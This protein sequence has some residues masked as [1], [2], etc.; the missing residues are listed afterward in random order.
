[1]WLRPAVTAPR[2]LAGVTRLSFRDRLFTRGVAQAMTS[3]S[4]ILLGG[5]GAA[6]VLA[7]GLPLVVAPIAAVAAWGAR[8]AVAIPRNARSSGIDPFSLADPWREFV[9]EALQAQSRYQAAVGTALEG[10]LRDR[11][12]E[13]GQRVDDGVEACWRIARRGQHLV[14]ARRNIDAVTA[15][16]EL[17]QVNTHAGENWAKG[18]DL[19]RTAEALRSQLATA[20]RMDEVIAD[21]HSRLRLLDARLDESVARAIELSVSADDAADLVGL[22]A[23]V[24]G[25]VT[26]MEALR[27]AL[28]ETGT[29]S[30]TEAPGTTATG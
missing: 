2:I 18:S 14:D 8:V 19:E 28:E 24:D 29:A 27:Q 25:L 6:L 1:M 23:D 26:E 22:G 7:T 17:E 13:I 15:A 10:P 20:Q 9:Q 11:L 5:A 16:Q 21:T 3:P 30:S 12:V 4:G